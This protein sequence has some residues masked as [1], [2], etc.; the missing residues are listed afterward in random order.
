MLDLDRRSSLSFWHLA[1]RLGQPLCHDDQLVAGRRHG[2]Q[3]QTRP[4]FRLARRGSW[5]ATC[6]AG[7]RGGGRPHAA[8]R[9]VVGPD[10]QG[11]SAPS[12]ARMHKA[13]CQWRRRRCVWEL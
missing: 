1:L 2:A 6:R 5:Q 10:A 4:G 12:S 11:D 8:Q 9:A 3:E 7:G 13:T